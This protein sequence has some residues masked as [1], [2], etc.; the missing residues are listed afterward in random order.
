MKRSKYKFIALIVF[1]LVFATATVYSDE[2]SVEQTEKPNLSN[3][4]G[5]ALEFGLV[6][7][8]DLG[9]GDALHRMMVAVFVV[10]V[11]GVAALY[12]S[13]KVVPKFTH[14][15]GKKIKVTETL[16][17]GSRKTLYLVEIEGRRLLIGST[18]DR[19]TTL[20]DFIEASCGGFSLEPANTPGESS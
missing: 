12:V 4:N 8:Q 20:A 13:K 3:D 6:G 9:L 2:L 1:V 7:D 16:H 19:I 14:M 5:G 17:L 10:V 11:L 15:Q 18:S